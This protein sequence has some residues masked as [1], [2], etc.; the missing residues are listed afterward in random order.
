M[1]ATLFSSLM[2]PLSPALSRKGRG[3]KSGS[4]EISSPFPAGHHLVE[5]PLL[6]AQEVEVVLEHV[7]AERLLRHVAPLQLGDRLPQR[8]GDLRQLGGG[9]EVS[10]KD[11]R[12]LAPVADAVEPGG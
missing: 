6:G 2:G 10:L 9:V 1:R 8:A 12:R 7:L 4:L 3:R 11:L 5:L